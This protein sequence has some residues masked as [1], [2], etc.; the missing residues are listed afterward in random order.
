MKRIKII[1]SDVTVSM[2]E[3]K[4]FIVVVYYLNF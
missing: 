3:F 4:S 1:R 2:G